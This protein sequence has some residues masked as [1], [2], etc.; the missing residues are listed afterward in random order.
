MTLPANSITTAVSSTCVFGL[1]LAGTGGGFDATHPEQWRGLVQNRSPISVQSCHTPDISVDM[2][3]AKEH[4][5]HI[6]SILNPSVSELAE[7]SGITRQA[8]Y[9][10]LSG[11]AQPEPSKLTTIIKLSKIADL[12]NDSGIQ[13]TNVLLHMKNASGESLL[14]ILKMDKP[15]QEHLQALLTEARL[16][17]NA[18]AKVKKA[19]SNSSPIRD[20]ISYYSIPTYDEDV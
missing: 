16:M 20:E 18:E 17:E 3:S 7:L 8:V 2:R 13:R 10:W 4:L 5:E 15:Y 14:D 9:K 11:T 19:L 12:C 1:L 6:R